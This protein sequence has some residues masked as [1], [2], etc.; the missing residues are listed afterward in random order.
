MLSFIELLSKQNHFRNRKTSSRNSEIYFSFL[1][2]LSLRSVAL[3]TTELQKEVNFTYCLYWTSNTV[4]G[5]ISASVSHVRMFSK[6]VEENAARFRHDDLS[7][8]TMPRGAKKLVLKCIFWQLSAEMN[9]DPM[10]LSLLVSI[11]I[12]CANSGLLDMS[13][14]TGA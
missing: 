10:L 12:R 11:N 7:V 1:A 14:K 6:F 13:C 4:P 9:M 3:R 8:V 5:G 2:F